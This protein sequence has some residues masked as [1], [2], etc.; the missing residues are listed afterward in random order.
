MTGAPFTLIAFWR[1]HK[2]ECRGIGSILAD[3]RAGKLP[4]V[5]EA[6]SGSLVVTDAELALGAMR[7]SQSR[8]DYSLVGGSTGPTSPS[9]DQSQTRA[10]SLARAKGVGHGEP[11]S[12]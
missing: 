3:A 7:G 1:R 6:E 10:P 5:K 9:S 11:Q 12:H 2:A 8:F 4:G